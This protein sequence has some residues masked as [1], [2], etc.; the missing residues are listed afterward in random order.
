M[1]YNASESRS[2]LFGGNSNW[3]GPIW[4]PV[5]WLLIE[6]LTRYHYFFRGSMKV[7]CPVGSGKQ[8]DLSE[9]ATVRWCTASHLNDCRNCHHG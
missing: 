8:M 7:E 6:S 3:R 1:E 5:N 4:L 9:V 2:G